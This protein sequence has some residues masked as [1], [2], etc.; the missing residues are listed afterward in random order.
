MRRATRRRREAMTLVE[1]MI[2][3]IIMAMIATAVGVAVV[4]RLRDARI[5]QT[6][7]DLQSVA[8]AA[9]MFRMDHPSD[10]PSVEDLTHAGILSRGTRTTDA[11]DHDFVLECDDQGVIASSTGPDGQ[12]ATD[13][14]IVQGR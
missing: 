5:Q 12:A 2:V 3:V 6:R 14:D 4:P 11:W 13:D 1:I 9:D 7:T 8:S 10:C